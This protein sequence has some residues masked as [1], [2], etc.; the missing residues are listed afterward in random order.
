VLLV[1]FVVR[2]LLAAWTRTQL[3]KA[4]SGSQP[5]A[6]TV[7]TTQVVSMAVIVALASAFATEWLGVHAL[8]GAFVAGAIAPRALAPV[9]AGRIENIVSAVLLPVF[10]AFTGLRTS[11]ALISGA[12][13]WSVFALI[14]LVAVAGKMGGAA[15]AA[16]LT[17]MGWRD[18]LS[19][20]ALMNTRGL[21]ELVILN[22][23]LDIGV[24]SPALFAMMVLMALVTTVMTTPLLLW[25]YRPGALA[26]VSGNNSH[27]VPGHP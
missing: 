25:V 4:G 2:P 18:A 13:L 10:F 16:R 23:G 3:A 24:I 22:V 20:G 9:I 27:S 26:R 11:V 15:T 14:L 19:V 17:G 6:D 8:F 12:G 21:M 7:V 1:V 5:A